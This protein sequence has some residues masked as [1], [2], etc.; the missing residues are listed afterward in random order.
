MTTVLLFKNLYVQAFERLKT[1][2]VYLFKAFA[3][4]VTAAIAA[5][6]F[7]FIYRIVTGFFVI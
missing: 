4:F 2:H 6:I 3:Y 1:F 7:A 5:G